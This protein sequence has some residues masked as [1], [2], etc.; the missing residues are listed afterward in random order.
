MYL[1]KYF[2]KKLL[3]NVTGIFFLVVLISGTAN[4][5]SLIP[6]F[7]DARSGTSGFQ[8]TKIAVD[9]RSAG[10][11]LSNV[12]DAKDA[13][14]LYWNPALA[15]QAQGSEVMLAHTAYFA[16]I[17]MEYLAYMQKY[18]AFSFGG[19]VQYLNS[20]EMQ[21]TTEFDHRGTG[22]TFRTV[23]MAVGLTAS[24]KITDLF[25]YG[26]TLKYLTERIEEVSINSAAIDFGFF[27]QVGETGLRFSVGLNNFGLDASPS[28]KTVRPTQEGEEVEDDF[29]DI[30]LPTRFIISTAYDV[31]QSDD[32]NAVLT[33]QISNPSDNSEQFSVGGEL[34]YKN[35][36]F[37][38]AG[39]Q[40]GYQEVQLPSFG[41]GLKLPVYGKNIYA[42]Y[43]F[44]P[45]DRLGSLHRI[46][47]RF[48]L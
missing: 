35:M 15:S 38:R 5:Q 28:G 23:H 9:A 31:Y 19:S 30:S 4:A 43:S 2:S 18:K 29:E 45:Y 40:F 36:F 41:A 12:A 27:Y 10:M 3:V 37:L 32:I 1:M 39:Y 13:S 21:E 16:D 44:S 6:S 46:G 11:G 24:H 47:L 20:G 7:G 8:F 34:G 14:S 26:L 17:S 42:D 33:A 48:T 25:S 22:R